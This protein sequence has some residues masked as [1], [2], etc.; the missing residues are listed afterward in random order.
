LRW[1]RIEKQFLQLSWVFFERLSV[2]VIVVLGEDAK[3]L[4]VIFLMV[5]KH[6]IAN[7]IG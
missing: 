6:L 4:G 5:S 2:T 3:V 7:Q 1:D